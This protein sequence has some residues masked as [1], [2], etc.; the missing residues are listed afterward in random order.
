MPAPVTAP[1]AVAIIPCVD[2]DESVAF[3]ARLGFV[4]VGDYG[5]YRLLEAPGGLR[6]H[7]RSGEEGWVDPPRNPFGIY[8][9]AEDVD[10]LAGKVS[11][12]IIGPPPRHMPWGMYEFAVSDPNGTLVR[13]GRPS[14]E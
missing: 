1:G 12:L 9:Y 7:L 5:D 8:I 10:A 13:I 11:E 4:V 14:A 3:Y 2:I 6:L